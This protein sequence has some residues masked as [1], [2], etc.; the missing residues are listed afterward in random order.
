MVAWH[1]KTVADIR[2]GPKRV[3]DLE[4]LATALYLVRT[5]SGKTDEQLAE[6]M[7]RLKPHLSIEDA[8]MALREFHDLARDAERVAPGAEA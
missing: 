7:H 3:G 5:H 4:K 6:E 1:R 8:R 2:C